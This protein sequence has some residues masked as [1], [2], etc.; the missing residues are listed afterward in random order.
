[1]LPHDFLPVTAVSIS[2]YH[3]STLSLLT[4]NLQSRIQLA[5][6]AEGPDFGAGSFFASDEFC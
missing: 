5:I 2:Q 3:A 6:V 4:L 1:M